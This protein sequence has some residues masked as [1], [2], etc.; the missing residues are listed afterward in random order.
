MNH[1]EPW[2]P[3]HAS[4]DRNKAKGKTETSMLPLFEEKSHSVSMICHVMDIVKSST[5][6]GNPQ[7]T[8]FLTL[9]QPL[10][11]LA[12]QIQWNWPD[13]Y[14]EDKIFIFLDGLHIEMAFARAIGTWLDGSGWSEAIHRS[15]VTGSGRAESFIS[16]SRQN[17]G[18]TPSY[19][20][21]TSST[22]ET[23]RLSGWACIGVK[24]F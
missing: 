22:R 19:I 2:A 23:L 9:D 5:E 24:V 7:Q 12:K 11:A 17:Y 15:Q 13:E 4:K 18:Q 1:P 3:Y 10:Y 6:F 16:V 20:G 21:F 14:G 8:P